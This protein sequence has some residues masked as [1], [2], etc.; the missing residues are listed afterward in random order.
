ML[1]SSPIP[2]RRLVHLASALTLCLAACS[3][4][5]ETGSGTGSVN[6]GGSGS[7]TSGSSTGGSGTGSTTTGNVTGFNENGADASAGGG[8]GTDGGGQ[9]VIVG[10]L[11]TVSGSGGGGAITAGDI[12]AASDGNIPGGGKITLEEGPDGE[13]LIVCGTAECQCA[14][15]IDNDDDGVIDGLDGECT[16]PFDDDEGSF[17]TGIPGDNRDPKWQDCFFDG[18]SGA[19]DDG[20]RYHTDCITGEATPESDPNRCEVSD[21]CVEFCEPLTPPGCDCFGCCTVE[22]DTMSL[23]VLI[24]DSCTTEDL[25]D[26]TKCPTC[27]PTEQCQNE[28]GECEICVG[29]GIEDLPESCSDDPPPGGGG[30]GS[31]GGTSM[32]GSGTG[33]SSM[34]GSSS[35]GST[36]MGGGGSTNPPPNTC[37]NGRPSCATNDDCAVGNFCSFG[38]CTPFIR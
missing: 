30:N 24:G 6:S 27:T 22:S 8:E 29:K 12:I 9:T 18:N 26:E 28:C 15:G 36:S 19:G 21:E 23:T 20:C 38:C 34:A 33:G 11:I 16:G 35:G 17:S 25:D 3:G 14:D 4:G 10:G 37:D 2:S 5:G 31:G 1:T 13:I 7:G 32:G